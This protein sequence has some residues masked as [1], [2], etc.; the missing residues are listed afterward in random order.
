MFI[1]GT[2]GLI[3]AHYCQI[4]NRYILH[5]LN[6]LVHIKLGYGREFYLSICACASMTLESVELPPE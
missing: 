5:V 4:I 3:Q 1:P 6:T 2:L